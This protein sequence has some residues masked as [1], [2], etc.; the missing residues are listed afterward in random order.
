M[1]PFFAVYINSGDYTLHEVEKRPLLSV[2]RTEAPTNKHNIHE[3]IG[4]NSF[5]KTV[6]FITKAREGINIKVEDGAEQLAKDIAKL[7]RVFHRKQQEKTT[8]RQAMQLPHQ[9]QH[10]K[11]LVGDA[12]GALGELVV[13]QL[14]KQYGIDHTAPGLVE[15]KSQNTPD[16]H[17]V[18]FGVSLDV[19]TA[20]TASDMSPRALDGIIGDDAFVAIDVAKHQKWR[21]AFPDFV[22]YFLVNV[23]FEKDKAVE[24]TVQLVLNYEVEVAERKRGATGKEYI[25]VPAP[26][27]FCGAGF[28]GQ[29]DYVAKTLL[30]RRS[31]ADA[32]QRRAHAEFVCKLRALRDMNRYTDEDLNFLNGEFLKNMKQSAVKWL[33]SDKTDPLIIFKN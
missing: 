20:C 26:R 30:V 4:M 28:A 22:G 15:Y 14:L 24:A 25:A 19:K 18:G 9:L 33:D 32:Q 8:Y 23:R 7:R 21:K 5:D 31:Y 10:A 11:N 13:W 12:K 1:R 17:L 27:K 6:D 16:F 2:D 3:G 29:S